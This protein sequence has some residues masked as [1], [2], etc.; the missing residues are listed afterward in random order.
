MLDGLHHGAVFRRHEGERLAAA[1]HAAGAADAVDVRVDG[2]RHV[3]VDHVGDARD[4]DPAGRDVGRHEDV[5]VPV[6]EA[7]ER[8]LA[9]VLR[10][11]A[12]DRGDEV[13]LAVELRRQ[14][15]GAVLGAGEHQRRARVVLLQDVSEQ[16]GLLGAVHRV[17]GL[18]DGLGRLAP[19]DLDGHGVVQHLL[20]QAAQLGR[21]GGGEEHALGVVWDLRQDAP[22]VGQ[23][24]H[25]QQVVGLV[26]H[27]DLERPEVGVAAPQVV[28]ETSGAHH[29]DLRAAAQRC[30]LLSE[31]DATVDGGA[32]KPGLSTELGDLAV[33][34]LRQLAGGRHDQ[35][36]D[37]AA[38]AAQQAL[39]DGEDEAGG[40]AGAGLGEAQHVPSLERRR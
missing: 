20:D 27:H 35:R 23:E 21:H 12:L 13:V 17:E 14:L 39:E 9:L 38:G 25:V 3:V 16:V 29:D 24:A 8:L 11:V 2:V 31:A 5:V 33:D 15:L 28:E 1:L 30:L 26:E 32:T 34:L 4:V 7:V 37:A 19:V 40:L 10:Q 18:I 22:D 6:A 36:P